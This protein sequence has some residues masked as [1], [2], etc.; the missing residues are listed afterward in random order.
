MTRLKEFLDPKYDPIITKYF[1]NF[2]FARCRGNEPVMEHEY[3]MYNFFKLCT[4][5]DN[6]ITVD[7]HFINDIAFSLNKSFN[8]THT[9]SHMYDKA[10]DSYREWYRKNKPNPDGT[11]LGIAYDHEGLMMT[12]MIAQIREHFSGKLPKYKKIWPINK[13]DLL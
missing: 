10:H 13:G 7:E 5:K 6:K 12:Y 8:G 9:F 4:S 1:A 2:Y 3:W 11:V